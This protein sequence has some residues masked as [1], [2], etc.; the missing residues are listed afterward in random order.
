MS[1]AVRTAGAPAAFSAELRREALAIDPELSI[2]SIKTMDDRLSEGFMGTRVPM[3]IASAFAVVAL[4]LAAIGIYG[5]LAYGVSQRRREIG[6]RMALGS[7]AQRIVQLVIG[8]GVRIVTV[9]LIVGLVGGAFVGRA[10][11]KQ[12]FNVRPSDPWVLSAVVAILAIVALTAT[13]VP[14]RRAAKVNPIQ[15]LSEN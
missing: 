8:D 11:E 4:L 12:L 6:I 3:L 9:G 1:L 2:F 15:A 7:S 5:V 13:F 14:A 10:M